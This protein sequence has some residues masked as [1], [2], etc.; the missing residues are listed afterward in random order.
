MCWQLILWPNT[1]LALLYSGAGQASLTQPWLQSLWSSAGAQ[2]PVPTAALP[3]PSPVGTIQEGIRCNSILSIVL[4]QSLCSGFPNSTSIS[5]RCSEKPGWYWCF[6]STSENFRSNHWS[7]GNKQRPFEKAWKT[8]TYHIAVKCV[9]SPI[10]PQKI[11]T[12]LLQ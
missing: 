2:A 4:K 6:C 7:C 12:N 8:L 11:G 9:L 3:V 5:K 1:I 10:N